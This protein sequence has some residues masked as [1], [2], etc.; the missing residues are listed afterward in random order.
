M[1]D[2]SAIGR[3]NPVVRARQVVGFAKVAE[4]SEFS[5]SIVHIEWPLLLFTI[6]LRT[7]AANDGFPPATPTVANSRISWRIKKN[8]Q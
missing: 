8:T 7:A 3:A 1:F 2:K 4:G 5:T 6:V